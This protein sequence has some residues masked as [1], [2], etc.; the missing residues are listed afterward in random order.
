MVKK[1]LI[2]IIFILATV[3]SLDALGAKEEFKIPEMYIPLCKTAPRIDGMLND[4]C[5]KQAAMVNTFNIVC[6]DGVVKKHKAY[7]TRDARW[8]YVAFD[9]D[10]PKGDRELAKY[11]KH[12]Q[13]VQREDNVQVSFDPGTRGKLYYQFLVN[14][15]NIRADFRMTKGKGRERKNFNIPWRSATTQSAKGWKCEIALPFSLMLSHGDLSRAKFNLIITSFIPTRDQQQVVISR[16]R[17]KTSWSPLVSS[18]N[19]P[20]R[21][22]KLLKM[23]EGIYRAPFL[24]FLEKVKISKYYL[25]NGKYYYNVSAKLKSLSGKSAKVK[26]IVKDQPSNGEISVST[27]D[28]NV[29]GNRVKN[30]IIPVPVSSLL[31]RTAVISM[32]NLKTAEILQSILIDDT[33]DL[34]LFSAYLD[35]NYYSSEKNAIAVCSI[36]LPPAG[37]KGLIMLAK[38][39]TGKILSKDKNL[40]SR[41]SFKIPI[42]DLP[43]EENKIKVQLCRED[44]AVATSQT[45]NLL[46]RK[47]KPGCEW[48]IDRVNRQLL[49]NGKAFFPFGVVAYGISP[50]R[51]GESSFKDL[52]DMNMNSIFQWGYHD[53]PG[54]QK[55]FLDMAKKYGLYAIVS[56]DMVACE[57]NEKT[58]LKDPNNFFVSKENLALAN[59]KLKQFGGDILQLKGLLCSPHKPFNGLTPERKGIL[60]D[61]FYTSNL[62]NY[63][64]LIEESKD[65]SNLIGY[66]IFDEPLINEIEQ[67]KVGRK[68]YRRINKLDG[69]HPVFV[70]Y[71]SEIPETIKAIDWSDALGTDPYWIPD[72]HRRNS[73]NFVSKIVTRTKRRADELRN[74]CWTMPMAEYW[75]GSNKRACTPQE[76]YCQTYLALIHGTKGIYYY[77]YPLWTQTNYNALKKLGAQMKKLGPIC[78]EPDIAQNVKYTPGELNP[79]KDKYTD[80][81][82]SLK[83]NPEGGY[84]LLAANSRCYPVD[85]TYRIS[86]LEK[87]GMVNTLFEGM[88]Y[89]VKNASFSDKFKA[90]GVRAYTFKSNKAL[91]EAVKI[92][93][94]MKAYPEKTTKKV[95]KYG[96]AG[97]V[98][99][100][101]LIPNP[102]FEQLSVKAWP[103]Y[104]K[105][106]GTKL[107]GSERAGNSNAAF[108][109]VQDKPFHGKR[110]L[111]IHTG[112][113]KKSR[114]AYVDVL[115]NNDAPGEY[116]F[117]FYARANEDNT[118][119]GMLR[120][121]K[122]KFKISKEWKR[123]YFKKIIPKGKHYNRFMFWLYGGHN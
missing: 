55:K 97:R 102:S 39:S 64:K 4:K 92:S 91:P 70:N 60:L 111:Q 88:K 24:P 114:L 59:K 13:L 76:Q 23:D 115:T 99:M 84:V 113:I 83:R 105:Y 29:K 1:Y 22:G 18:F 62:T 48:K 20:E 80:I 46:K 6:G 37:L 117:S 73:P 47:A 107:E 90:Y 74:V 40:K 75:S 45:F 89:K 112:G 121:K 68:F 34:D 110:C 81:Q 61:E 95:A 109:I 122:T 5:W 96:R 85:V 93:V 26:L 104:F 101:N 116:V 87:S 69:Y 38:D 3:F 57:F 16:N 19:E 25:K 28:F 54:K 120:A 71:S 17:E 2:F 15:I 72:G 44:G 119:L 43:L 58:K 50:E 100:K 9:V 67:Y 123:Y 41:T 106:S 35:R 77:F 94:S 14:K 42:K 30:V 53:S 79:E 108:D 49:N 65:A 86:L 103:D 36:N 66:F 32:K 11:F 82:V 33:S 78:L 12:D 27:K 31:K 52:A 7:V 63:T 56:P 118:H 98:G 51:T 10:F 21:F 8:L